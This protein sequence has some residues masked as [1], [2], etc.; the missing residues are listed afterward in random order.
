LVFF[1]LVQHFTVETPIKKHADEQLI[2]NKGEGEL[3]GNK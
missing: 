1:V 2:I 3:L